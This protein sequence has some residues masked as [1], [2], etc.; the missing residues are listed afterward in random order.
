MAA[1]VEQ[2][3]EEARKERER[4][5]GLHAKQRAQIVTPVRRCAQAE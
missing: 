5:E 3:A 2:K 1:K 4:E